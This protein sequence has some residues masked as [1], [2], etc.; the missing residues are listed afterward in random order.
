MSEVIMRL[1]GSHV[2]VKG[3]EYVQDLVRCGECSKKRACVMFEG[4]CDDNGFCSFGER[5]E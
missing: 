2:K 1:K 3:G 4:M 5:D